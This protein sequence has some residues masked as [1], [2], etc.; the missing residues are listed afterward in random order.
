[1]TKIHVCTTQEKQYEE[2][3]ICKLPRIEVAK[4]PKTRMVIEAL[5]DQFLAT[6]LIQN[7]RLFNQIFYN[8]DIIWIQN[9]VYEGC[10]FAKASVADELKTKKNGFMMYMPTNPIVYEVNG[11]PYHL[12][13]RIDSIRAKPNLDRL[14]LEPKPILSAAR[15]NDLLCSMVMRFY[16]TYLE[17]LSAVVHTNQDSKKI[18]HLIK[19]IEC[20]YAQFLQSVKELNDYHLNWHPRGNGHQ[21]LLQLIEQLQ[22][23]KSKPGSVLVDFS[24]SNG[25]VIVESA[26]TFIAKAK[27][28]L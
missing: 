14:D 1:M 10:L 3:K 7:E 15:V 27:K 25:Y 9:E 21:L 18:I 12:I 19:Y 13:T 17:E 23:L 4:Q 22:I 2:M 24:N 6:G 28:A 20:E 11:E 5:V 8:K 16:H 26:N